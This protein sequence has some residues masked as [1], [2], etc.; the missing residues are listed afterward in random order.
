[1]SA[2]PSPLYASPLSSRGASTVLPEGYYIK[3]T[4]AGFEVHLDGYGCLDGEYECYADA[5]FAA[6]DHHDDLKDEQDA[7][8]VAEAEYCAAAYAD[9]LDKLYALVNAQGGYVEPNDIAG[10][11]RVR[12]INDV[13]A[14]IEKKAA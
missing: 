13:L 14:F 4:R 2:S 6:Q 7:A 8:D 11:A 10:Q 1:M 5:A 3:R 9:E 12:A